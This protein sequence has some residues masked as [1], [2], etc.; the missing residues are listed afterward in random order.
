MQ[1]CFPATVSYMYL[2]ISL[3]IYTSHFLHSKEQ[4]YITSMWLMT[5]DPEISVILA[6][7]RVHLFNLSPR[8]AFQFLDWTATIPALNLSNSCVFVFT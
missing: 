7:Q 3:G 5:L 6:N 4:G 8:H 2:C 1:S